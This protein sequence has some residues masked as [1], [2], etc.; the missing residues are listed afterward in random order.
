LT[1]EPLIAPDIVIF[2][3]FGVLSAVH[4]DNQAFFKGYEINNVISDGLLPS[5]L[6][7]FKVFAFQMKPKAIFRVGCPLSQNSGNLGRSFPDD[8]ATP[9]LALPHQGGGN[10]DDSQESLSISKSQPIILKE[11]TCHTYTL[12]V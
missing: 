8:Y 12:V 3:S 7:A 1:A 11:P 4:F 5:K 2:F 6:D 10:N 9:T